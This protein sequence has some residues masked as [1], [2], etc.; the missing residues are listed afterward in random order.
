[1]PY[2]LDA[3]GLDDGRVVT[4]FQRSLKLQLCIESALVYFFT[5]L[6]TIEFNLNRWKVRATGIS[7]VCSRAIY[8]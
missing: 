8:T 6:S 7:G 1:M 5:N 4:Y 3:V 2:N